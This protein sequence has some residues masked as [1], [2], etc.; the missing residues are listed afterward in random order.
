V[1]CA[2]QAAKDGLR[3]WRGVRTPDA[4]YAVDLRG[5]WLLYDNASDPYQQMN[6]VDERG[7]A[8]LRER[9]AALLER[10][11]TDTNDVLEPKDAV[12]ARYGLT[13]VWEERAALNRRLR[14]AG[15]PRG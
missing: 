13:E 14:A 7:A 2:D 10:W 1:V 5:P 3:E 12:L 4:T 9:M 15:S 11:M 6:L 8:P